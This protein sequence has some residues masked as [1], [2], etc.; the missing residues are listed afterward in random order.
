MSPLSE[1]QPLSAGRDDGLWLTL[2]WLVA[3]P[4]TQ[5]ATLTRLG[6]F[7]FPHG[8]SPHIPGALALLSEVRS[9]DYQR[10]MMSLNQALARLKLG[11]GTL[12][13]FCQPRLLS[14]LF[15]L[16][17]RL[18]GSDLIVWISVTYFIIDFIYSR[19][20]WC[21]YSWNGQLQPHWFLWSWWYLEGSQFYW[22]EYIWKW[23]DRTFLMRF[24]EDTVDYG[25]V[26]T[27]AAS[28]QIDLNIISMVHLCSPLF[29]LH[30]QIQSCP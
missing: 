15:K 27:V 1:H 9:P 3:L 22:A 8:L 20:L 23:S 28:E 18:L 21:D 14:P 17:M 13:T 10:N 2:M 26:S 4:H 25:G 6:V 16:K 29:F 11:G 7:V 5:L 19:N 12:R 30:V 24:W